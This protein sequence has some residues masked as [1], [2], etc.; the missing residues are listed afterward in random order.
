MILLVVLVIGVIGTHMAQAQTYKET[1]VYNFQPSPDGANPYAGVFKDS[2]ENLYGTTSTGGTGPCNYYDYPG[3]GVVYKVDPAGNETVLYNFMGAPDDGDLPFQ[4]LVGIA[5]GTLYG[6]TYLGGS[7]ECH[8]GSGN[9]CG[10]VFQL[11]AGGNET[12][13]HNFA[14]GKKDGCEPDG[15]LLRDKMGNLYGTTYQCGASNKGTVF[16]LYP[17]GKEAV[18][19]SFTGSGRIVS[20]IHQSGHGQAGQP[21]RYR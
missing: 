4:G 17:T 14:G 3:C 1:I 19:H 12:I 5:N 21:V 18:L 6:T 9:G 8:N 13:L 16:K 2:V 7:G 15:R 11:D 10:I 20:C